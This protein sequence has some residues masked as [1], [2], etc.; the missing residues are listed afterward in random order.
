M[1]GGINRRERGALLCVITS[2]R[3]EGGSYRPVLGTNTALCRSGALCSDAR[4]DQAS[5]MGPSLVLDAAGRG[6][7]AVTDRSDNLLANPFI[8]E[9]F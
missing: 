1:T 6:L 9:S 2:A 5:E 3:S 4:L 8:F 7:F